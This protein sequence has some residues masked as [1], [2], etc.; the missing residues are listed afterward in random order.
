MASRP[1]KKWNRNFICMPLQAGQQSDAREA[2]PLVNL[3]GLECQTKIESEGLDFLHRGGAPDLPE[4]G[5]EAARKG[6]RRPRNPLPVKF[7]NLVHLTFETLC[8]CN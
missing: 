3:T 1:T 5:L 8:V 4:V 6:R 7:R 2:G